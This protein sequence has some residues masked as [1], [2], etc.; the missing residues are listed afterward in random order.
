MYDNGTLFDLSVLNITDD[1]LKAKL[2]EDVLKIASISLA[3]GYPTLASVPHSI[4]NSF[5][6]LA[7]IALVSDITFSEVESIKEAASA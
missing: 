7:S 2:M 5:K 6:N 4:V 1:D 3:I